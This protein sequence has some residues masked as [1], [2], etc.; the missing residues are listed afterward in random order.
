VATLPLYLNAITGE[1]CHLVTVNDYLAKRDCQ[2]MGPIFHALGMSVATI[3]HEASFQYDP[4][5]EAEDQR[6]RRLKPV[7]RKQAYQADITYGRITSSALTICATTWWWTSVSA[8]SALWNFGIVDEVDYILIDE[9]RTPLIISGAAEESARSTRPSR[10][11]CESGERHRLHRRPEGPCCLHHRQRHRQDG[12]RAE[13]GGLL[14]SPDLYD[15]SNY[16]LTHYLDSALKAHVLFRRDKDYVVKNGEVIIVD[17]FTGR[18]MPGRRYSE[19][20]H[21]AIEARKG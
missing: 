4:E 21:Q 8:R 3:Q 15:P 10:G 20:L 2:W 14:K 18:M 16:A 13:E 1:G 12:K 9:A 6:W 5:H 19:G 17:E 11:W 7:S